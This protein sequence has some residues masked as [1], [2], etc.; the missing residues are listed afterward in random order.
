VPDLS[1]VIPTYRRHAVLGRTL[2]ALAGQTLARE[3]FE[4]LVVDDPVE[5]DPDA[6]A[7]VIARTG[8]AARQ[9]HRAGRGVSSARNAGWREA[10]ADVIL[11]LG[12]D[13]LAQPDLLDRHLAAHGRHAS[14]PVGVLGHVRWADELP[15]TPLMAWL[16]R[17]V[18]SDY[19]WLDAGGAP[20]WGHFL[21]TN[22]SLPRTALERVGGFDEE[23]F[24][25]LYE[26]TD[27]GLRLVEHGLEL[28]YEP[29]ARGEHLHSPTLED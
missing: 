12:D 15:R 25:F 19:A 17:G 8:L 7:A 6:V 29:R 20:S 10:A 26:D 18:Q 5:D 9:L 2:T 28:I 23:H 11:F 16:E 4:V 21:T 24:P 13:I 22:A 14:G 27:L 3:R 1:V